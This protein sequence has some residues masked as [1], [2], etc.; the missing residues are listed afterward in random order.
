MQRLSES[1]SQPCKHSR[2]GYCFDCVREQ[3]NQD[4][5]DGRFDDPDD[6]YASTPH[7]RAYYDDGKL[8]PPD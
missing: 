7:P 4:M 2:T 8:M 6:D 1:D 3:H 5:L